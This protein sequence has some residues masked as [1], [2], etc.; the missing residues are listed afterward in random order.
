M[1]ARHGWCLLQYPDSF[2]GQVLRASY[3]PDGNLLEVKEGQRI[4]YAWHNIIRGVQAMI[5]GLIWRVGDGLNIKIWLDPWIPDGVTRSLIT[6]RGQT[7]VTKVPELIDLI[8]DEWDDRLIGD[9][10]WEEDV[11]RIKTQDGGL[12]GLA[13]R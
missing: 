2:Y 1:L 6:P 10:F 3:F 8:S 13:L 11:M 9:V 12:V 5:K 4:S 7:L